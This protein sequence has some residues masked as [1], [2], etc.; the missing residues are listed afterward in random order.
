MSEDLLKLVEDLIESRQEYTGRLEYIR[1][2][3]IKGKK[4]YRSDKQY[5]EGLLGKKLDDKDAVQQ[6]EQ[7]KVRQ[8]LE[9]V[10]IHVFLPF[11]FLI[12]FAIT[13]YLSFFQVGIYPTI[14]RATVVASFSRSVTGNILIDDAII[15][16]SG[17][18]TLY[19]LIKSKVRIP[20]IGTFGAL[21][22]FLVLKDQTALDI[23]AL[24]V[25]ILIVGI[26]IADQFLSKKIIKKRDWKYLLYTGIAVVFCF[27]IFVM[28]IWVVYPFSPNYFKKSIL[29]QSVVLQLEL[30]YA[31]ARL[32]P[33][34]LILVTYS[35]LAKPAFNSIRNYFRK[36]NLEQE[37]ESTE[38]FKISDRIAKIENTKKSGLTERLSYGPYLN[39]L[40]DILSVEKMKRNPIF[41]PNILLDPKLFLCIAIGVSIMFAIYPYLPTINPHYKWVSVDDFA[42]EQYLNQ[43]ESQP[44]IKSMVHQLFIIS[45]G[46]RPA[47]LLIMEGLRHLSGLTIM[48]VVRFFPVILG[49]ALVLSVY[50]FVQQGIKNSFYASYAALLTSL[51]YQIVVG[52]YAGFIAN[53]I[54]LV[55]AF[56]F[57]TILYRF[58]EKPSFKNYLLVFGHSIL[59]FSLYVYIDVYLL[60][61]LFIFL[62]ISS[63][64]FRKDSVQLKK[65]LI[66]SSIFAIYAAI[67][68]TRLFLGSAGLYSSVFQRED[69]SFTIREFQ[70]RWINF[71]YFMHLYVGGFF[72]NTLPLVFAFVWTLYAKYEKTFDRIMLSAIFVGS[73]PII[74]GNPI[75]QSRVF[76]DM[77][78]FVAAALGVLRVLNRKNFSSPFAKVTLVLITV[79]IFIYAIRSLSNLVIGGS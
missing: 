63:V 25:T 78:I 50:Y 67:F 30:F 48:T 22:I 21:G 61:T 24:L 55:V 19:F 73:I 4:I 79:D 47:T 20:I 45:G 40:Y 65:I 11:S 17:L 26:F 43:L 13:R 9:N 16:V 44:T 10:D 36:Q 5:L 15:T 34:F 14:D 68:E 57:F 59:S 1:D 53:W 74:F 38:I 52:I 77:P 56:V 54:G 32:S 49:P 6:M 72:A 75:L 27:E 12:L 46:D 39:Y 2:A 28:L 64:K 18:V 29:W 3:L 70:N 42:Y 23:F 76:Y 37:K 8:R 69:I 51:S 31:F 60:L 66:L 7:P 35:F 41:V 58:W 62:G 33:Y 71:P